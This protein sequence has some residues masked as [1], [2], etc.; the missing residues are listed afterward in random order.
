MGTD[1]IR[2]P[3]PAYYLTMLRRKFLLPS[4]SLSILVITGLCGFAYIRFREWASCPGNVPL[5]V[6]IN[7]RGKPTVGIPVTVE[8][9]V[10]S[11]TDQR[12]L[13]NTALTI[14]LPPQIERVEGNLE[15][16]GDL[17]P[18]ER[19]EQVI[20]VKVTQ[21]GDWAIHAWAS[22]DFGGGNSFG[23]GDTA[24]ILSL[25]NSAIASHEYSSNNWYSRGPN[26]D[27]PPPRIDE[28]FNSVIT[29][30]N[31]P[32]LNREITATYTITTTIP[33]TNAQVNL[34][35]PLRA[36]KVLEFDIPNDEGTPYISNPLVWAGDLDG[37]QSV[38][39]TATFKIDEI[40]EGY[41]YGYLSLLEPDG[42]AT[43]TASQVAFLYVNHYA[44]SYQIFTPTP[45]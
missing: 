7:I 30:S 25:Q 10:K 20:T 23:N 29:F 42:G 4:V 37:G 14:T 41:I 6:H 5:C 19:I 34:G 22:S 9:E 3:R 21:P 26:G 11:T 18:E 12:M 44:G 27:I 43:Q 32:R 28:R 35:Y 13:P 38:S 16:H 8:V 40:G 33:I 39:I 1:C 31:Q 24:F 45:P 2:D 17:A 36:L 15:W